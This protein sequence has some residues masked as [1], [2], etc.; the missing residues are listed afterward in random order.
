MLFTMVA[1]TNEQVGTGVGAGAGAGLGYA[2]G[3]G[4]GAVI[5]G[6]VVH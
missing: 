1:C 5:V 4:P 6:S 2:I 3:R